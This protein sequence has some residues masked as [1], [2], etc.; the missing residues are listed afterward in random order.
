MK[1]SEGLS[2]KPNMRQ[3]A[4]EKNLGLWGSPKPRFL[5]LYL[6]VL[7]LDFPQTRKRQHPRPRSIVCCRKGVCITMRG[8]EVRREK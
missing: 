4:K 6:T 3:E 8:T 5:R 7:A 2:W 1:D